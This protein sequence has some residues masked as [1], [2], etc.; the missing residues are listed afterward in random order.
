VYK[1]PHWTCTTSNH[2]SCKDPSRRIQK[3]LQDRFK[4]FHFLADEKHSS[5]L[6]HRLDIETS[7]VLLVATDF[8]T[9]V[10]LGNQVTTK[11][12]VR[13]T[14]CAL[15]HGSLD[16]SATETSI[17]QDAHAAQ[18]VCMVSCAEARNLMDSTE[19]A[20]TS[21]LA[22]PSEIH[23]LEESL[24]K[25]TDQLKSTIQELD[26]VSKENKTRPE[27]ILCLNARC[28]P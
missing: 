5:G 2:F 4:R 18:Q 8:R 16:A 26:R 24:A 17:S 21:S 14:Y 15:M 23:S 11:K 10:N 27:D 20:P 12:H 22:Q 1:H 28:F 7:G 25:F 3:W 6:C 9:W 13:K 19:Q